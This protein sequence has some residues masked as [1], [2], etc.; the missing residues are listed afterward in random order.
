MF[1]VLPTRLQMCV[2]QRLSNHIIQVFH[3]KRLC[4]QS[5]FLSLFLKVYIKVCFGFQGKRLGTKFKL[6][7]YPLKYLVY[8]T[9]VTYC[10][11]NFISIYECILACKTIFWII[12]LLILP[13]CSDELEFLRLINY[14]NKKKYELYPSIQGVKTWASYLCVIT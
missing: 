4:L 8:T 11:T 12:R 3:W 10:I 5:L 6:F 14:I 7:I 1:F 2:C 13:N 9:C